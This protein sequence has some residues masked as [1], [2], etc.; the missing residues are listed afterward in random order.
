MASWRDVGRSSTASDEASDDRVQ[1]M[2]ESKQ[3]VAATTNDPQT[4]PAYMMPNSSQQ[5]HYAAPFH[6]GPV[7]PAAYMAMRAGMNPPAASGMGPP[8]GPFHMA[9]PHMP[10]NYGAMM[11][12]PFVRSFRSLLL[13]F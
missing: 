11:M 1:P 8:P 5:Q 6:A 12:S 13:G 10:P 2:N 7:P 4:H 3:S 9:P